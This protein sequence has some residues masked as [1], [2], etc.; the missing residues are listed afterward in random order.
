MSNPPQYP[1]RGRGRG[2]VARHNQERSGGYASD[3][4]RR[5]QRSSSRGGGQQGRGAARP[6]DYNPSQRQGAIK[7][8]SHTDIKTL[9]QSSSAEVVARVNENEAGFLAAFKHDRYCSDPLMMK[10][11]VKLLYLLVKSDD[12]DRIASRTLARI[13]SADGSY[14]LF[15]MKLDFLI[16]SMIDEERGRIKNENIHYLNYL[17]EIGNQAIA[18]IPE[19]VLNTFPLLVIRKTIQEL[20]KQGENLD[21]LEKKVIKLEEA[22][23]LAREERAKP[24]HKDTKT[25]LAKPPEHFVHVE[26]LQSLSE[27]HSSD[28]KI[29]L[30]KNVVKGSYSSWDHYLDVQ[31]RLL[32]EDFVRPLRHGIQH[33]CSPG[34]AKTSQDVRIYERVRVLNPVCLFT[35]IGFQIQFDISRLRRVNWEYS[36]RLIFGSLLCLSTDNFEH[37]MMFATVVKRDVSLLEKGCLIVKFEGDTNGF[38]INPD[39]VFTMVES[40]AYFEAYRHILNK[41]KEISKL[42]D[43]IP[44]KPYIIG[45]EMSAVQAPS[46]SLHQRQLKFD[47]A[48][49]LQ[50]RSRISIHD[51]RS[52]PR[53]EDTCLDSS[54]LD[55][56]KMALT[57]EVSVIQGPPG[58]GKTFIGLKIVEAFLRNRSVWDRNKEAP[59]LVVCYTNHALDQFLEGIQSM[60]IENQTPNIVRIGGRCK[61]ERLADCI[62]RTKVNEF[63]QGNDM[64]RGLMRKLGESRNKLFRN[65]D[66]LYKRLSPTASE[67]GKSVHQL[68]DLEDVMLPQHFRQLSEGIHSVFRKEIEVWLD[69]WIPEFSD[70]TESE[71]EPEF[72]GSQEDEEKASGDEPGQ[73]SDADTDSENSIH[74]D[75]EAKLAEDDRILEGEEVELPSAAVNAQQVANPEHA[76]LS[77]SGEDQWEVVRSKESK[78]SKSDKDQP[79]SKTMSPEEAKMVQDVWKLPLNKKWQLYNFWSQEYARTRHSQASVLAEQYDQMC[80]DF[81]DY[82]KKVDEYVLRGCD[83]IGITTT[84]AAKHHHV[85]RNIHPKIVI[86][87]EA[88]EIFEAHIVTSLAPSVQQLVLIGDHKQLQPK[89]N[90]YDL[91][92]QYNLSVSLFERLIRNHIPFVTLSVQHRM[93]PEISSLVHPRI[94]HDLQDH[95]SVKKYSHVLGVAKDVFFIDHTV[96]EKSNQD[97]DTT[98]HVNVFEAEYLVSLCRYLLKQ[99]YQPGAITILTMYRGQLLELKRKMR[100]KDFE[101][102]RVAAVDD[103]QGEE[104]DIILLSLVRSNP[105]QNIG[106]LSNA[107]RICVSLSRAKEGFYLI[108]NLSMLR[109]KENTVWPEIISDLERKQCVGKS[110]PLY[111]RVHKDQKVFAETPEDFHKC[112]EGG[113]GQLCGSRLACRHRCPRVCHPNDM[114]HKKYKCLKDC[115]KTLPCGHKCQSRCFACSSGCKPCSA[116]TVKVLSCGHEITL[117]CSEKGSNHSCPRLCGKPLRCG[118]PCQNSCSEPCNLKCRVTVDKALPCGHTVEDSCFLPV[119]WIKCPK[120]CGTLLECGHPCVGTCSECNYGRLHVCCQQSCGR[121]MVCGHTC[122]FPCA[123]NCPPCIRPCNNYCVHSNC[124]KKCYEICDPC[125]EPCQWQCKHYKCTQ[126][127]GILCDRPPC[128]APCTKKLKCGH[129]CIS[130]CG[131][132]CPDLCRICDVEEVTDVFFGTEDEDDACFIVLEDCS[133]HFEVKSL[134]EWVLKDNDSSGEI[135]FPSCPR[136]RTPI[137][138]SLRYCNQV[139]QTLLDVEEIKRKQTVPKSEMAEQCDGL[140]SSLVKDEVQAIKKYLDHKTLHPYRV[141][142]ISVQISVLKDIV[143]VDDIVSKITSSVA[144][145]LKSEHVIC[146]TRLIISSLKSIKSFVMQE[147]LSQQQA[148][149]VRSELRRVSCSA[150]VCDLLCKLHI[151]KCNISPEDQQELSQAVTLVHTSG[152]TRDKLTEEAE[153]SVLELIKRFSDS[154]SVDGLSKKDREMIVEAMGLSKGHWYKCPN[155]HVY[156]IG[157]C[158]GAMQASKCP[159]CGTVIGGGNHTLAAGNVHAPEMDGSQYPAWS[160]AANLAN[161]D[162]AQLN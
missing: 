97:S 113:C 100:R 14:A 41:L 56:L 126:P 18:V 115:P 104:N 52:W 73:P 26:V 83:V 152:W 84:G 65:K 128:D 120:K 32:R 148:S 149:D 44:F 9:S 36:R 95:D 51:E 141:N 132:K 159:E 3:S 55:A 69:L 16:K 24:V 96:P 63:Q 129:D 27:V 50:V 146:D 121:Q 23:K 124:P 117:T 42:S 89:P 57:K 145:K 139:K 147:F 25:T 53:A 37:S 47:L 111:C 101:G 77:K 158:G 119:E 19:T 88:A 28:D 143:R 102:V 60:C 58:T 123:S 106:F 31:Y 6:R 54:Q 130:L 108:G 4:A 118:H 156:C 39:Q 137:R 140:T 144:S 154:Y 48:E 12:F 162:P 87:E 10:H 67:D 76:S 2:Y 125:M 45:A 151:N 59:I 91:G 150:R 114:D 29:F 72:S 79:Q 68:T 99:G 122:G 136:C 22:F 20:I 8:L 70:T 64:P 80:E 35:G 134:D 21:T 103:F 71:K 33:Y 38:Q 61:S 109:G 107:N 98:T 30:R 15:I 46:Y 93:R 43:E 155:G 135:K 13:L 49:I 157:E 78:K 127:C 82:S 116:A 62:L 40:T 160:E 92:V 112:P 81:S 34:L 161:F 86:F 74:V 133:H 17:I 85:L 7:Y 105:E 110:L 66:A 131:E 94:Y 1:R 11:L 138:K 5:G 90:C 153:Q 75:N 142:A